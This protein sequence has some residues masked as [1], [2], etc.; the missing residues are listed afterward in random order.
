MCRGG[1][2]TTTDSWRIGTGSG[3][4]GAHHLANVA[5]RG[6]NDGIVAV[7]TQRQMQFALS[8][9]HRQPL[10][11]LRGHQQGNNPLGLRIVLSL[12]R[13]RH[14]QNLYVLQNDL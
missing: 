11:F 4:I 5:S 10:R 6:W 12:K 1:S 9:R 8:S 2:L 13:L 3:T 14:S 7:T